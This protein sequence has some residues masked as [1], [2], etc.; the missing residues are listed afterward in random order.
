MKGSWKAPKRAVG[1]RGITEVINID[2]MNLEA[3]EYLLLHPS[4]HQDQAA[5]FAG[6]L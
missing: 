3:R 5:W 1:Q 2:R 6:L 4:E